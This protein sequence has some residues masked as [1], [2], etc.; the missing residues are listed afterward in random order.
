MRRALASVPLNTAEGSYSRGANRAARYHCAAGSMN[1]VI[2]GI[3]TAIA[4][5]YVESFDPELL[6]RLRMVV[7]TLFKNAR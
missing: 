5:Q 3:E 6:D 1:E 7:A 4:F 2:A